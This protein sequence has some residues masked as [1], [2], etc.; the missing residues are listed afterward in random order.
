MESNQSVKINSRGF[1][2]LPEWC[3]DISAKNIL[4]ITDEEI[5]KIADEEARLTELNKAEYQRRVDYLKQFKKD[6][7]PWFKELWQTTQGKKRNSVVKNLSPESYPTFYLS[8]NLKS[9]KKKALEEQEQKQRFER[10]KAST[11][12]YM[13]KCIRYLIEHGV[14]DDDVMMNTPIH[15]A[16]YLESTRLIKEKQESMQQNGMLIEFHGQNC[17]AC[18]GWDG[19]SHRCDCGNRRVDWCFMGRIGDMIVYGEAY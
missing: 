10:E 12:Q 3:I 2:E 8:N 11:A 15:S 9:N 14:A 18:S 6:T 7:E 5:E 16:E 4:T 19:I 17:D 1:L 13:T